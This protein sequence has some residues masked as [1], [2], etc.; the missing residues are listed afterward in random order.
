MFFDYNG[1]A[2][3]DSEE[4]GVQN[5]KVQ[6]RDQNTTKVVAVSITDSSGDY[7]MQDFPSGTYTFEIVEVDPK[8][9]YMCNGEDD[10]RRIDERYP[11]LTVKDNG[12]PF[13]RD[14]RWNI[15]LMEGFMTLPI[16]KASEFTW[17]RY[18]DWDPDRNRYHWWNDRKGSN[19]SNDYPNGYNHASID[20][21]LSEGEPIL[22]SIPGRVTRVTDFSSKQ[23]VQW[24]TL[25]H[26]YGFLTSYDHISKSLVRMGDLVVRGQK[27]AESGSTGGS[28]SHL[29]S[30]LRIQKGAVTLDPFHPLFPVNDENSGYY[31]IR[32]TGVGGEWVQVPADR[33]PAIPNYWTV[34]NK[35]Q[36]AA[37]TS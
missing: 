36:F 21:G 34:Y 7:K 15:G 2:V 4:P 37:S 19:Q 25:Q 3:Q 12:T 29:D 8:F 14:G 27:I 16:S 20:Y 31:E 9:G 1:N 18:W 30:T 24:V 32:A 35:P 6:L 33:N 28:Y 22:A 11:N 17:D 5:V 23:E 26:N 13:R 10:F